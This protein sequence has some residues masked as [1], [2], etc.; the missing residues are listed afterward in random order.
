MKFNDTGYNDEE[1][2]D[3][4]EREVLD[5]LRDWMDSTPIPQFPV[6]PVI[7][8]I[9]QTPL[10]LNMDRT[11]SKD[12]E[13]PSK[14]LAE[15]IIKQKIIPAVR[16]TVRRSVEKASE[17]I[18]KA[19]T[20]VLVTHF[21]KE[22]LDD[23]YI[24]GLLELLKQGVKVTRIVYFHKDQR[25]NY[26]WLKRFRTNGSLLPG[27]RELVYKEAPTPLDLVI[28]DKSTVLIAIPMLPDVNE[29]IDAVEINARDENHL[30]KFSRR[31]FRLLEQNTVRIEEVQDYP[32]LGV[33]DYLKEVSG[34]NI[35]RLK[36]RA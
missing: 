32:Y 10:I 2:S 1:L 25:D 24:E 34:I 35:R 36:K 33:P 16:L 27:Y 13:V 28:V 18:K 17:L 11:E 5:I 9:Y 8:K 23:D 3:D 19:K 6:E 7:E 29:F 15:K 21:A 14:E 22:S 12:E 30:V 4:I 26:T 31:V 20:S